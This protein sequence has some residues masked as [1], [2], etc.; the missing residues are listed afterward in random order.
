VTYSAHVVFKKRD[1][2][3]LMWAAALN[4]TKTHAV[5][6]F[7]LQTLTNSCRRTKVLQNLPQHAD[8]DSIENPLYV[9]SRRAPK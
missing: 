2:L 9:F 6:Y 7:F 5:S 3:L 8:A 4:T 1:H